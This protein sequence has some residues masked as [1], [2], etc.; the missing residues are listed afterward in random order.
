MHGKHRTPPSTLA[1]MAFGLTFL[2]ALL[3]LPVAFAQISGHVGPTTSTATKQATICNVL[4]YGGSV[5]SN[6]IG[7]AINSAFTNCVLKNS[8]ST[9]YV[10]P[11]NYNMQTWV[12]LKGGSKWAFQMD[13][14]ITRT[15]EF[16]SYRYRSIILV[17]TEGW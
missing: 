5:G 10:P 13:G 7:P 12:T 1:A 9:L 6:D 3:V 15:S 14:V 16:L 17:L 11:G 4:S 8:G 2:S